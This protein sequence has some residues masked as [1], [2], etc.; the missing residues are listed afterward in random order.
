MYTSGY[1]GVYSSMSS[2]VYIA[3]SVKVVSLGL[4][5]MVAQ[6]DRVVYVYSSMCVRYRYT[7]V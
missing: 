6:V 1:S 7:V 5:R 2:G 3:A 4:I